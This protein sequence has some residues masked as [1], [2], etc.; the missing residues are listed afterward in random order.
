VTQLGAFRHQ[1]QRDFFPPPPQ[2]VQHKWCHAN[3]HNDRV[4]IAQNII[5]TWIIRGGHF[6]TIT[7]RTPNV[8]ENGDPRVLSATLQMLDYWIR[9]HFLAD[10]FGN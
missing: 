7:T 9:R 10:A 1:L 2:V 6:A 8:I 4:R 5:N 3:N